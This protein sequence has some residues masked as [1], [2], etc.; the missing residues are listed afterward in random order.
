MISTKSNIS[1]VILCHCLTSLWFPINL[2]LYIYIYS[3]SQQEKHNKFGLFWWQIVNYECLTLRPPVF[4]FWPNF[5]IM[6]R[7][8]TLKFFVFHRIY[9]IIIKSFFLR[10]GIFWTRFYGVVSN[11]AYKQTKSVNDKNCGISLINPKQ[12]LKM[13]DFMYSKNIL[14]VHR[15]EL[16]VMSTN[17]S[18]TRPLNSNGWSVAECAFICDFISYW[19]SLTW[20]LHSTLLATPATKKP[21]YCPGEGTSSCMLRISSF[22]TLN[23]LSSI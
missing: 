12:N 4:I 21:P 1:H 7:W 10:C 3:Y 14:L 13:N 2:N 17:N 11:S 8:M 15:W 22:V 5:H 19:F 20:N 23:N 16:A 6:H 9:C 18:I